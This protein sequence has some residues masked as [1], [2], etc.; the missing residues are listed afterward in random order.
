MYEPIFYEFFY[1]ARRE[2]KL[3]ELKVQSHAHMVLCEFI[4]K[5]E[6]EEHLDALEEEAW[7]E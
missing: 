4:E 3:D 6:N 7:D 5:E 1:K 2:G